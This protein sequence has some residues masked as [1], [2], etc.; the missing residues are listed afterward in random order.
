MQSKSI[1]PAMFV[2]HT[3]EGVTV[4]YL[5]FPD[6]WKKALFAIEEQRR[7]RQG[8]YNLPTRELNDLLLSWLPEVVDCRP[9]TKEKN[10][11]H[12]L[13]STAPIDVHKIVRLIKI[14]LAFEYLPASAKGSA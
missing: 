13:V 5:P 10:S 9:L 6:R 2:P 1:L 3:T 12:W 7:G 14:W 8:D 11:A 4:Y